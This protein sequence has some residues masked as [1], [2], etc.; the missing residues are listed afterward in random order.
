MAAKAANDDVKVVKYLDE[1]G[2]AY[3]YSRLN[4]RFKV[5]SGTGTD[6]HPDA[7]SDIVRDIMLY[8]VK[9]EKGIYH[10]W[11]YDQGAWHTAGIPQSLID[12]KADKVVG[13]VEGNIVKLDAEGNIVDS[14]ISVDSLGVYTVFTAD[15]DTYGHATPYA[16]IM[17][18]YEENI[19]MVLLDNAP[20]GTGL[21]ATLNKVGVETFPDKT[22]RNYVQFVAEYLGDEDVPV[23]D[24]RHSTYHV[25]YRLYEGDGDFA[26]VFGESG[27]VMPEGGIPKEDLA[28]P[29]RTSLAKADG[30]VQG[31]YVNGH[32]YSPDKSGMVNMVISASVLEAG[33][34]IQLDDAVL[35]VKA[36]DGLGFDE[37]GALKVDIPDASETERGLMTPEDKAL[38][39]SAIQPDELA[40]AIEP[41][42]TKEEVSH[43][44][45]K[46]Y[47]DEKLS[48]KADK[49]YV[50]TQLSAK[51]E[52]SYVDSAV[53]PKAD[54]SYV[55]GQLSNKADTTYV[56][57][58]LSG[59]VDKVAGK[60]LSTNDFTDADKSKLDG[61]DDL[62]A[63]EGGSATT[64]VT[65]GDKWT[66]DN[67][68]DHI[69]YYLNGA[70]VS[71]DGGVSTLTLTGSDGE[72]IVFSVTGGGGSGAIDSI[73]ADGDML[74]IDVNKNVDIPL[75]TSN[76]PGVYG[77]AGL[78]RGLYEEF[79]Q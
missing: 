52:K 26:V 43:K 11:I 5:V 69:D 32:R 17:E 14:G 8:L 74:T 1:A 27:Y 36:G 12:S 38:L 39:D 77:E 53:A 50:D 56:D 40:A 37:D 70:V 59:K 58:G 54:K 45:E 63:E 18:L 22:T 48:T 28:K 6:Q 64:L 71:E 16:T 76:T 19:P 41:L 10:P 72:A 46:S 68:Q 55:D 9:D 62:P 75:A 47:V 79:Q 23:W 21:F 33:N 29:V 42:A 20:N 66:W 65:T 67:K 44:A 51:A 57:T 13:G 24:E 49:S 30:S 60:G 15:E 3:L 34:G 35:S 7:D 4:H 61:I 31:I 2:I 25:F 73:S 78:V